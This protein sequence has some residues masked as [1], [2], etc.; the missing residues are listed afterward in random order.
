MQGKTNY[1][2]K[3]EFVQQPRLPSP[4]LLTTSHIRL[5][6]LQSSTI[7]FCF[8]VPILKIRGKTCTLTYNSN[9]YKI[10]TVDK[11]TKHANKTRNPPPSKY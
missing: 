1:C 9:P 4:I 5:T 6:T 11:L 2:N 7:S 8:D 10:I 3:N